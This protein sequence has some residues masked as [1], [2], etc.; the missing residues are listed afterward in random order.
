M[1]AAG[2][3]PLASI[4]A[5]SCTGMRVPL[6]TGVPPSTSGVVDTTPRALVNRLSPEHR[7]SRR[8]DRRRNHRAAALKRKHVRRLVRK[9]EADKSLLCKEPRLIALP[10]GSAEKARINDPV[11]LPQRHP[12]HGGRLIRCHERCLVRGH[13]NLQNHSKSLE[14]YIRIRTHFAT[15]ASAL[16]FTPGLS[17]SGQGQF[18]KL[19]PGIPTQDRRSLACERPS[20]GEGLDIS[21]QQVVGEEP[22]SSIDQ[23]AEVCR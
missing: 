10:H 13:R 23:A 4:S 15:A 8:S 14:T 18:R 5:M 19:S 2:L 16:V 7:L 6:K 17:L 22:P 9:S 12:R 20:D 21:A 1:I 3:S 11:H